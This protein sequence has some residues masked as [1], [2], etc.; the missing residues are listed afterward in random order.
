MSLQAPRKIILDPWKWEQG[1]GFHGLTQIAHLGCKSSF[2]VVIETDFFS[3]IAIFS[4]LKTNSNDSRIAQFYR[5]DRSWL[6][7]HLA[8]SSTQL[9]LL[10]ACIFCTTTILSAASKNTDS[11]NESIVIIRWITFIDKDDDATH[12]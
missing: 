10:Y 6:E 5:H 12:R 7:A 1:R 9:V 8:L 11:R 2:V 4:N 3:N